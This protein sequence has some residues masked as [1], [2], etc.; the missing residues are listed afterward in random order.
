VEALNILHAFH[1]LRPWW[2]PAIPLWI[3]LSYGVWKGRQQGSGWAKLCDPVLLTYLVGDTPAPGK[4]GFRIAAMMLSG[5]LAISALAGPVWKQWPQPV[6]RA[7]SGMIIVLDLSRSMLA[8]DIKPSRMVRARQKV[9]DILNARTGGQTGLIVFAGSAFDVV[10]LTTDKRAITLLL[11]SLTPGIMPVQGSNASLALKRAGNM[12]RRSV[13]R[14]GSVVVL[15]DGVDAGA[16]A[17][18]RALTRAGDSVSI[19]AVGTPEGAP[20]PADGG[21]MTDQHGK[22]IMADVNNDRLAAVATAGNG[23]FRHIRID[24]SDVRQLP[25][26]IPSSLAHGARVRTETGQMQTDQWHEEGPWLLLAM[27]PLCALAFRRGALLL[28]VLVPLL[29]P[30][31]V[32]AMSWRDMWH[33]RDQQAQA[34]MQQHH[35]A[36]AASLFSHP[37]WK[38]AALYRAGKYAGAAK[39]LDGMDQS[40]TLYNRGNALARAGDLGGSITAYN[41]A[42]RRNASNAD[43]RTNRDLIE[44]LLRRKQERSRKQRQNKQHKTNNAGKKQ[45]EQERQSANR[46]GNHRPSPKQHVTSPKQNGVRQTRQQNRKQ[47]RNRAMPGAGEKKQQKKQRRTAKSQ[48]MNKHNGAANAQRKAAAQPWHP[49]EKSTES[50]KA[51]KQW[52]RRIPDD[53]GGLLRRKFEYQYRNR[54]QRQA[55]SGSDQ[56]W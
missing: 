14:H 24:N 40:D 34:L 38:A 43:A 26:L 3:L 55:Q 48:N 23:I 22:I 13:I 25:G 30:Y 53:P 37:Q 44:K 16:V 39:A 2:L 19:L 10:P 7:Q 35:P 29:A 17:A 28:L 52:L 50:E 32:H 36:A 56:A 33:T 27:L 49:D 4:S 8:G 31:P 18:A 11:P 47:S 46:Q 41:Q 20:I 15:C 45:Q 5:V 42:L 1:F 12:F 51:V 54:Q 9:R 21:F 6:F